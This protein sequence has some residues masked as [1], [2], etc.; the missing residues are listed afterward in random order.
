M[1]YRDGQILKTAGELIDYLKSLPPETEVTVDMNP[2][3]GGSYENLKIAA[4]IHTPGL[5][6]VVT[7]WNQ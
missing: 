3:N 5:N 1:K 7:K 2:V 6:F 4:D